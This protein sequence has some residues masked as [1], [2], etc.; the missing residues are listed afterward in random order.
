LS[1]KNREHRSS[2]RKNL[3]DDIEICPECKVPKDIAEEYLWLN[4]G[5]MVMSRNLSRRVGFIESENLDPLYAGIGDVLGF[6]IER[7]AI[8]IARKGCIDYFKNLVPQ[9]VIAMV[10]S[11]AID[12][13]LIIDGMVRMGR[14]NGMGFFELIEDNEDL[15]FFR[16]HDPFSSLLTTGIELGAF[17]LLRGKA[18]KASCRQ[19][20]P[21]VIEVV[22]RVTEELEEYDSGM[23]IREYHH[24]DGDIEFERCPSCGVPKAMAGFEWDLDKGMIRNTWNGRRMVMLG[25]EMQDPLFAELEKELG[26]EIPRAVV[27]AQRRF[28]MGGAYS[29]EELKD[30][31]QFRMLLALRGMGNVREITISSKS[32]FMRIDNAAN[33][34]MAVGM[35]QGLFDKA[36]GAQSRVDWEISQNGDLKIEVAA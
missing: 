22:S 1:I 12:R 35:A 21:E 26:E 11:G 10:R 16:I 34:L 8:E 36:Y 7:P 32:L 3:M 29:I 4:S 5:V 28:V 20:S 18:G 23:E 13:R 30:E 24:R 2:G 6:S 15:T 33:H 27:E 17:E 25:P 9:E 19:L 14:L 31:N